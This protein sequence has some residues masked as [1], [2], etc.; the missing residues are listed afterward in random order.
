MPRM[1]GYGTTGTKSTTQRKKRASVPV[2]GTKST[3]KTVITQGPNPAV[4]PG[5]AQKRRATK[6]APPRKRPGGGKG[7]LKR[8]AY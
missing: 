6:S 5:A 3:S 8:R 4:K 7:V 2:M 1:A